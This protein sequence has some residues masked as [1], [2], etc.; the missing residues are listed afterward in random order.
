MIHENLWQ[1]RNELQRNGIL[2]SF[3]GKLTQELIEEYGAAVKQYLESVNVPRNNV[4]QTFSIFI[5]QTQNIKNYCSSKSGTPIYDEIAQS[6][7]VTIG[8][9]DDKPYVCSGNLVE[10]SDA[11]G[12]E[13]RLSPLITMDKEGLKQLYKTVLKQDVPP[14]ANGS[15]LGLID[16]AR[17]ASRPLEYSITEIDPRFSFFTLKAVV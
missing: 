8:N 6:C 15:G 17:K 12:L 14:D 10:K 5:E 16:I 2:I 7:I 1:V 9:M 11:A 13:E 3:T 4:F